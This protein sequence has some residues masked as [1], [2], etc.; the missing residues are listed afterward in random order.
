LELDLDPHWNILLGDNGVGKTTVLRSIGIAICGKD[1]REFAERLI[2]CDQ[3]ASR[4]ELHTTEGKTYVTHVSRVR[5]GAADVRT[6]PT[7]ILGAEGWLTLGFPPLRGV[8]WDRPRGPR[9][10]R[11]GR[12]PTSQDVLP[13]LSGSLD[14]RLDTLKQWIVNLDYRVK[15]GSQ[16][17]E[18]PR[19]Y[20]E[21]MEDYFRVV[22]R[23]TGELRLEFKG[24]D[25][26]SGRIDIVTDDGVVPIE[27]L[28]QG[29]M[30]LLGWVGILM[31]RLY[32]VHEKAALPRQE[33]ALVL[34]DEIDAHMHPAWQR[35][36]IPDLE[37]LF[38]NVQFIVTTHSPL[39][40]GGMQPRN[41]IHFK[42]DGGK[43]DH[44][45]AE[46]GLMPFQ[47]WRADQ[48]LTSPLFHL[49][50]SRDPETT[51][52]IERYTELAACD[53]PTVAQME[54][55]SEIAAKLHIR[56]PSSAEREE[57]REALRA[58]ESA[59]EARLRSMPSADRQKL[60]AEVHVQVQEI[61]TGSARPQ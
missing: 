31:Q 1:S 38:P 4:I 22:G 13:L 14:P 35:S 29:T 26:E 39:V 21:L 37:S 27:A 20:A 12:G 9:L 46:H 30:S 60:L 61:L 52:L 45:V 5:A 25:V 40:I 8:T 54:E 34:L 33:Y 49:E 2:S 47:G 7:R 50:S 23:L 58:I 36:L 53:D 3:L 10:E 19:R 57:S 43:P 28:S 42:R 51:R 24:V 55:L 16:N 32:E 15:S 48:L 11:G 44:V 17:N 6:L 18:S 56:L 59:L 41:V